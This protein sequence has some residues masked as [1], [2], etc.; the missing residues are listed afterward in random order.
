M[1]TSLLPRVLLVEDDTQV[2]TVIAAVLEQ[3]HIQV[4][5]AESDLSAI[6]QVVGETYAAI[7]VDVKLIHG[8]GLKVLKHLH[9]F[10]PNLLPKLIVVTPDGSEGV[11]A[12][13]QAI[14]ICDVIPRPVDPQVI[15]KIVQHCLDV[16]SP[17]VN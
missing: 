9:D 17:T 14:G 7:I 4:D 12:E 11:R 3:Y 6:G 8:I 16:S 15:L 2:F 1:L 10:L 13:L 5:R